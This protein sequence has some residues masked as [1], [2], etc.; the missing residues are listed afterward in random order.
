MLDYDHD[1]KMLYFYGLRSIY[2]IKTSNRTLEAK[3]ADF[4]EGRSTNLDSSR[5]MTKATH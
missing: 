4:E 1:A 2:N 3:G 5:L